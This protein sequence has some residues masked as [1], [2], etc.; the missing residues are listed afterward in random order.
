[1]VD[2]RFRSRLE[3]ELRHRLRPLRGQRSGGPGRAVT[4]LE[5]LYDLVYVIAFA[6]AAEQLAHQVGEGHVWS[7]VGA[8]LFAIWAISWAWMNFSWF[9]SAYGNDD[10]LFR[11]LT[12]VQMVGAVVL[13]FGLPV[14]FESAAGGESPNN[15]LMVVGYI[16]MRVPLIALW[17][18]AAAQDARHRRI[19]V[20]YAVTIT[21]AQLLWLLTAVVPLAVP[22]TVVAIVVLASAEMVAPVLLERRIG[23]TPW[24]AGHLAER[25]GLLTLI[26]L[27]EV[28][29]ATVAAVGALTQERGWS[30][31][32]AALVA[33]G[34]VIAAGFWW[35]YFLIPSRIVLERWPSRTFAWRYAHLPMFGSIAAVGAGLRIAAAAIEGESL[36]VFQIALA[37]A[38]PVAVM[39]AMI[40]ITWSV[41][42]RS[43][44]LTHLPLLIAACVPLVAAL[45]VGA[46]AGRGTLDLADPGSV[47]A[48]VSVIVLVALCPVVEVVGHEA[49][50]YT[51]TLAA[52]LRTYEQADARERAQAAGGD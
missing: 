51:H 45:A 28:I 52:V 43:Y 4:P 19:D 41:L 37:L 12:I 7:A 39:I 1:M 9:A 47:A 20:A 44:D 33:S 15:L 35:A 24:N 29:A 40:F 8:Y 42:L 10:A 32:A 27:G 6:A 31:E 22:V 17:L 30:L 13:M 38:V 21:V 5:L 16:V 50:G 11:V 26:A 3:D 49:V 18:R 48:L 23:R 46:T 2:E 36:T 25:F 34:L 14:S